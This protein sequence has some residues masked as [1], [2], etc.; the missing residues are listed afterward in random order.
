MEL[1]ELSAN[2]IPTGG[3]RLQI[4][5]RDEAYLEMARQIFLEEGFESLTF[6]R[7]AN[8]TGFSRGVLYERFG[9]KAGLLVELGL[10][11]QVEMQAVVT[12]A[13]K[14]PGRARERLCSMGEA[15]WRYSQRYEDNMRIIAFISAD[16]VAERVSSDLRRKIIE[17]QLW[18]FVMIKGLVEDGVSEGDLV[19]PQGIKPE[20]LAHGLWTMTTGLFAMRRLRGLTLTNQSVVADPI[21]ETFR[22]AHM[23]C[24]AYEW[25]PLSSE[26]DYSLT[27]SRI[28]AYLDAVSPHDL[29][30]KEDITGM[31][32]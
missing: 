31:V 20:T 22:N 4:Y 6:A 12:R 11:C 7:L 9:S 17:N 32:Y 2:E 23:L 1:F 14:F 3:K 19:L 21:E 24:D 13:T 25:R 27:Q 15:M 28:W 29:S 5:E 18:P 26:W 30:R 16:A 8:A 10:R